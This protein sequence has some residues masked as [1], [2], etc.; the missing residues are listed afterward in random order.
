MSSSKTLTIDPGERWYLFSQSA[1]DE[2]IANERGA[3]REAC[4]KVLEESNDIG[5]SY[6][7]AQAIRAR[8]K[9]GQVATLGGSDV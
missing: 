6:G 8:G 7:L 4:A 5:S 1:L 3:E 2:L 9:G